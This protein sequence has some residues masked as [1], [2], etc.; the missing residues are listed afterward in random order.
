MPVIPRRLPRL[1]LALPLALALAGCLGRNPA[2]TTGSINRTTPDQWRQQVDQLGA[3][4]EANPRDRRNVI[5]YATALRA[6]GRNTQALAV[7]QSAILGAGDDKEM[8][9][10]YGRALAEDGKLQQAMDVLSRAHSPERPDWR[11]LSAQGTVADQLGDHAMAQNYYNAALK[12]SPG[13]PDVMSNLGLSFALTKRLSEAEQVLRTA[14][15]HPQADAKVRQNFVL[16]LGLQ[17]RFAEAEQWAARDLPPAEA[18]AMI[19]DLRK[20]VAQPNRWDMLRGGKPAQARPVRTGT[21][22]SPPR[23]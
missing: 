22:S 5:S 2:D 15:A 7:L 10:L 13:D 17:G 23:G 12:I 18:Q 14:A 6:A 16:V 20:M 11:I 1:V 4:Y 3:R 8:L 9:G 21:G 19:A